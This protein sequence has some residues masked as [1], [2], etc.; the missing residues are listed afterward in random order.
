MRIHS[1][2]RS[3]LIKALFHGAMIES[4]TITPT[5]IYGWGHAGP[6]GGLLGIISGLL[7]MPG[8]IV[9]FWLTSTFDLDFPSWYAFV[10]VVFLFQVLLLSYII[11]VYLR[12]KKTKMRG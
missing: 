5:V 6:E 12:I 7:N 10:A 1:W 11:F 2:D 8:F 4:V 9:A 3:T